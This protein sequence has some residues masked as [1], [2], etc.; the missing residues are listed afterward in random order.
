MKTK[1]NL[2]LIALLLTISA[3][4]KKAEVVEATPPVKVETQTVVPQPVPQSAPQA[5][6]ALP[7][8]DKEPFPPASSEVKQPATKTPATEKKAENKL[9]EK[10]QT[11]AQ[12]LDGVAPVR[13][14]A[15]NSR[16]SV[17]KQ[18]K[19]QAEDDMEIEL[20]SKK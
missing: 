7:K 16:I 20:G 8:T 19:K 3:C 6:K 14:E 4:E 5:A 2:V 12:F 11:T 9:A 13:E 17:Q 15:A 1:H 18:R 10:P